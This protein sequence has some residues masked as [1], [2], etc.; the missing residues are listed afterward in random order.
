MCVCVCVCVVFTPCVYLGGGFPVRVVSHHIY[1]VCGL[2]CVGVVF[3]PCV[4]VV[5]LL[6]CARV[7][8]RLC[9]Y[10]VGWLHTGCGVHTMSV[11]GGVASHWVGCSHHECMW[12]GGFTLGVVFTP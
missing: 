12:W 5:C 1:I 4:Y 11:C 7:V 10:V 8:V 3:T 9:V 6:S 2:F